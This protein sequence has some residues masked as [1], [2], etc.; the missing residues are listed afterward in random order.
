MPTENRKPELYRFQ[1]ETVEYFKD[2]TVIPLFAEQGCGKSA[3]S[4]RIAE[5]KFL[6]GDINALL[7]IA[8]NQV[9]AAWHNTEIPKWLSCDYESQCF[10]GTGGAKATRPFEDESA[11][12]ILCVNVDTFSTPSKWKEIAA[13]VIAKKTMVVLDEATCVKNI[14]A[15]RTKRILYEFNNNV[16]RKKALVATRP[17]TAARAALTGTPAT[18]GPLDLWAIMEFLRPNYF[19]RNWYSF[20]S[21]YS[22]QY[23]LP[24]TREIKVPLNEYVWH[25]IRGCDDYYEAFRVFGVTEDT[26]STVMAQDRYSGFYKHGDELKA[27]LS[28]TA[29]FMLL[30][31]CVND[32]PDQSYEVKTLRMEGEQLRCYNEM[33]RSLLA[34]Y[35]GREC[36]ALTKLTAVVRLQQISSGFMV[37]RPL[38]APGEDTEPAEALWIGE[39][40]PKLDALYRDIDESEPPL[41]II[42]RFSAEAGRIYNDLK[43]R[44]RCCLMTGWKREGSIE[45]FQAGK[46]DIMVANIRVVS[47]GFNLQNCRKMFFYSNTF[48]LEDRLQTEARIMRI[49]QKNACL[50]TDYV[51]E[52]T[53]DTKVVAALKTKGDFLDFIRTSSVEDVIGGEDGGLR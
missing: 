43:G 39:S 47:K 36:T 14:K 48:S 20:Q 40:N 5:Y 19:G 21:Y 44:Y 27:K 42:T 26:Y 28:E 49:G 10:G 16:W 11:L 34:E 53:V 7:I 15:L 18:N 13:W 12:H 31:D 24:R 9:H 30:R 38:S 41:I 25:G 3:M 17:L 33:K 1:Q 45:D 29:V 2:K 50:Y 23:E 46:F 37:S 6:K 51:Y 4:L 22:M 52:G 8:P 32:L 35:K